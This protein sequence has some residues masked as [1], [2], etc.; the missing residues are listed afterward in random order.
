MDLAYAEDTAE[1]LLL[2]RV[3]PPWVNDDDLLSHGQI[4]SNSTA[5][6]GCEEDTHFGRI[7]LFEVF[8]SFV[9]GIMAL[10][11]MI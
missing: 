6:Q 1:G 10:A 2:N 8:K 7:L 5:P 3:V 4:E 9:A 11:S